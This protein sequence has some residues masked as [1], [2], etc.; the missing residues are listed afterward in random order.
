[1]P[2]QRQLE[3]V[4]ISDLTF[5]IPAVTVED[6]CRHDFTIR[7]DYSDKSAESM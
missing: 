4:S 2:H 6:V 1:M 5:F 7:S 3:E